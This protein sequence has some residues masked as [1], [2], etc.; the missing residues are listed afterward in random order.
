MIW[1]YLA[2]GP[3]MFALTL[4]SNAAFVYYLP[5]TEH[6]HLDLLWLLFFLAPLPK[7][8]L[9]RPALVSHNKLYLKLGK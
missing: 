3:L 8:S 2:T 6:P 4:E 9:V 5:G 7:Q 1:S